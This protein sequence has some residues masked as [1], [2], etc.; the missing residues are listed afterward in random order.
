MCFDENCSMCDMCSVEYAAAEVG[1]D[2]QGT[3]VVTLLTINVW[4]VS[5]NLHQTL[6]NYCEQPKHEHIHD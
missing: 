2:G 6:F 3:N 5:D 1:V 4:L